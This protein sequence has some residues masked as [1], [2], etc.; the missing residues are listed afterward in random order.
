M[1][2]SAEQTEILFAVFIIL[3]QCW[4]VSTLVLHLENTSI[5]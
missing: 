3:S 4:I 1:K 5:L 2:K